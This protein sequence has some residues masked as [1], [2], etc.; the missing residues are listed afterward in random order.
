M[1]LVSDSKIN[2]YYGVL[3]TAYVIRLSAPFADALMRAYYH[4]QLG[5]LIS[6]IGEYHNQADDTA[7]DPL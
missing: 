7:E 4:H 6:L 5:Y 1:V 3:L 2:H